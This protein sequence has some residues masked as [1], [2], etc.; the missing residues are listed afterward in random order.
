MGW[1]GKRTLCFRRRV[2]W[3]HPSQ[4]GYSPR[5]PSSCGS[6]SGCG[7]G[8]K[9]RP[10]PPSGQ[11]GSDGG[12]AARVSFPL[13][14]KW[15][16][17]SNSTFVVSESIESAESRAEVNPYCRKLVAIT[18]RTK[19]CETNCIAL[20][21]ELLLVYR[22]RK[23]GCPP[24]PDVGGSSIERQGARAVSEVRK[25]HSSRAAALSPT[26]AA[27]IRRPLLPAAPAPH[28]PADT[29]D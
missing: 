24:G 14:T 2:C 7:R 11:G 26:Q 28:Y 9:L 13:G 17:S 15:P 5:Q 6:A 8:G 1:S 12:P 25:A 4:Y 16:A 18:N 22:V 10:S 29:P 23:T 20:V 3:N 19:P 21:P 27:S